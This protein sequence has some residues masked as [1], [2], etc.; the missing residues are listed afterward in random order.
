[1]RRSLSQYIT[2][3]GWFDLRDAATWHDLIMRDSITYLLLQPIQAALSYP[4]AQGDT[5]VY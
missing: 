2:D 3:I 1:M 4:V 5:L